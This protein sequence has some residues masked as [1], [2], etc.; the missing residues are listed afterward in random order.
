MRYVK[1]PETGRRIS[2]MN[3]ISQWITKD[4]PHL[5]LLDDDVWA[6]A[7]RRL[8][9]INAGT[10]SDPAE[11]APYRDSRRARHILT[12]RVFCGVCKG[13]MSNSGQD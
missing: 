6:A 9:T 1:D 4:V 3:P 12:G 7:Q 2:R 11:R 13:T 5:R 10:K 8:G